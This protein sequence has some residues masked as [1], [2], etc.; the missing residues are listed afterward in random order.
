MKSALGCVVG[1]FLGIVVAL[2]AAAGRKQREA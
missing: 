1:G 2:F